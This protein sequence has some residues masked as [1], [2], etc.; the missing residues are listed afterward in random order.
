MDVL[1]MYVVSFSN[2]PVCVYV[3]ACVCACVWG[4]V[5]VSVLASGHLLANCYG[6]IDPAMKLMS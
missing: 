1:W 6:L 5:C 4:F 2:I 3:R